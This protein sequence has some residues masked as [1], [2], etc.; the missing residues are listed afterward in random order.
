MKVRHTRLC[1][2]PVT[3]I[4]KC[5]GSRVIHNALPKWPVLAG[6]AKFTT[7]RHFAMG[8]KLGQP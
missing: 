5:V 3:M 2:Q 4:S 7:H 8:A 6:V 1:K